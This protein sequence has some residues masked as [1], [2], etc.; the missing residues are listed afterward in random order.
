MAIINDIIEVGDGNSYWEWLVD[1]AKDDSKKLIITT[2]SVPQKLRTVAEVLKQRTGHTYVVAH[3]DF[4]D[5][6]EGYA[7]FFPHTKFFVTKN[8]HAKIVLIEPDITI[9]GSKN[10]GR[11]NWTESSIKI[12]SHEAF[13]YYFNLI[14]YAV[15]ALKNSIEEDDE[16]SKKDKINYIPYLHIIG[17]PWLLKLY[18][19]PLGNN[20]NNNNNMA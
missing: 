20:N 1:A 6:I 3:E 19:P 4:K 7:P 18:S 11:S 14:T 15:P 12:K 13:Q 9:L 2:Y 8:F 5:N 17:N 10:F 16:I